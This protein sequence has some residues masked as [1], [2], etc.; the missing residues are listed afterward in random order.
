MKLPNAD[1]AIIDAAKIR[2][3]LLDVDHP[4]GG[5]KAR[6]LVSLGYSAASWQQL[7]HDIRAAH[8]PE[9]VVATINTLWGKRYEIVA[10]IAGPSGDSLMFRSVWQIDLGTD[11]P[12]LIT[13]YPE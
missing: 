9:N 2:D 8:L 11:A 7:E 4:Y 13:M 5:S 6:L 3:Y 1:R 12:R 10:P